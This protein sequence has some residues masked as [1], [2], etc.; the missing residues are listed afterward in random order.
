MYA[1]NILLISLFISISRGLYI[2]LNHYSESMIH[3]KDVELSQLKELQAATELSS[4]HAQINPHF[5]Y[6]SLNSIASL[7]HINADKTEKM[8]LSMS[9]LFKYSINR[10]G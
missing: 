9:D 5:L 3:Q 4:L 1:Q 10:K 8:S 7:A 2:Y 6:N